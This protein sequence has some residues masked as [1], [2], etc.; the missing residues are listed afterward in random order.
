MG[1]RTEPDLNARVAT[2][3]RA[4][5][6][7]KAFD[8]A[9]L[10]ELESHLWDEIDR[11]LDAGVPE[12][13]AVLQASLRLGHAD[14]LAQEYRK[15]TEWSRT[16][17]PVW[18]HPY[19]T[20]VM[21]KNYFKIALRNLRK[22]AGYSFINIG[23]LGLG[24]ACAFMIVLFVQ[25][26]FSYDAFHANK[27][28]LYRLYWHVVQGE[29]EGNKSVNFATGYVP[30]L[31]AR[32]PEL[33]SLILYDTRTPYL[34]VGSESQRIGTVGFMGQEALQA[35]TF[36][37]VR[38]N[39]ETALDDSYSILLTEGA[40]TAL[41]GEADP[42][43]KQIRYNDDFD[44][45]VT[46]VLDDLPSGSHFQFE[47]LAPINLMKEMMGADAMEDFTNYNYELFALLTPGADPNQLETKFYDYLLELAEGDAEQAQQ[48]RLELQPLTDMHFSTDMQ[49]S[50]VGGV[51]PMYIYLFLGIG[52]LILIIAGVNFMNLATA[53]AAKRAK[54]VGVRKTVG[55]QR[56]QLTAQFLGESLLLS[57]FAIVLALVL[58]VLFLPIFSEIIGSEVTFSLGNV[59]MLA[60]LV[61]IGLLAGLLAGLYPAFY[62]AAF[63]PA[64]VLKGEITK[65]R[66]AAA[67]RK[68]LIVLQFGISVF[69]IISTLT[70]YNQLRFMQNRALGFEKEQVVFAPITPPIQESYDAFRQT[71]LQNSR[72]VSMAKAGGL[73]GRVN[74]N[75][76]YNWPGQSAEEENG[77]S[78]Y[79]AVADYDYLETVGLTLIAGRDF[80]R[81][82]P[83]DF[84]N[85]YI[86]NETAAREIGYANPADA[87]G[88]PF[89][90]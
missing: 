57:V 71:V 65:G 36:P 11:L 6:Q 45:T 66:G 51:D 27:A 1:T 4:M 24:L 68:G 83:T 5:A 67:L 53:R 2:W 14:V 48:R 52:L 3:R 46:G 80:S 7:R 10:D 19:W 30:Q 31:E 54:E 88:Q 20:L 15:M 22:Q 28:R 32:Y 17:R 86:L 70:V 12:R 63:R 16:R 59:G 81:D 34:S 64:L 84:E 55:A 9:A 85:T 56:G 61:G 74:T 42:L 90:A 38:G 75:R 26:E 49:W 23:G 62:L 43:G 33:E 47:A 44:V 41:F 18:Q 82:M 40:A 25:H 50:K 79:T 8:D 21:W 29:Y 73:P 69:L 72:V 76:G 35:F 37:L 60:V 77:Q 78:F 89:R 58:T 13:H 87:V 39:P